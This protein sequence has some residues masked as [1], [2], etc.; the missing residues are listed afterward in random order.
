LASSTVNDSLR[1]GPF[2]KRL[3]AFARELPDIAQGNVEALHRTRVASRRLRELLP[4]VELDGETSRRLN[5]R[6]RKVTKQLGAVRELDVLM[7][8]IEELQRSSRYAPA[9][10]KKV[11]AAVASARDAA[12]ERL[13]A[14]LPTAKLERLANRLERATAPFDGDE[15]TFHRPGAS[16]PARGW[17]WALE[18]RLARRAARVRSTIADAGA[19][20]VPERLHDVRIALKK[21]RYAAELAREAGR[22]RVTADIAVLKAAQDLL[23][24]LHDL[25]V[26]LAWERD[27]QASS[28]PPDLTARRELGS[29]VHAIEDDCRRLHARYM[30]DRASLIAIADR[31][32][33]G[34]PPTAVVGLRA[35]G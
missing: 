9:A 12:R 2:R 15:A 23:G 8:L 27:V 6:L 22:R 5:R 35:T 29:L 1:Y 32:G 7:L 21:L 11:G 25:E 4:L 3:D 28:S 16:G 10:L 34:R 13:T 17:L 14:K 33:A 19:L 31:M 30:S 20:Y 26:L 24:R 18:A